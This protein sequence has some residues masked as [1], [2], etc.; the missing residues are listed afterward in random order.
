V[1]YSVDV[2]GHQLLSTTVDEFKAERL[3]G[4]IA[5]SVVDPG[6]VVPGGVSGAVETASR[7]PLGR[8]LLARQGF[9][10]RGTPYEVTYSDFVRDARGRLSGYRAQVRLAGPR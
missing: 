8:R 10:Y 4:L 3:E 7:D 2:G 5:F 1:R 6:G 9:S